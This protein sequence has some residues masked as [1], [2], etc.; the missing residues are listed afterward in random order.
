MAEFRNNAAEFV[1]VRTY[2][3]WQEEKGRRETW[4]ETVDRYLTFVSSHLGDKI[5]EKVYRKIKDYMLE[6]AVMPSMRAV[7]TAGGAAEKDNTCLY[8]CSFLNINRIDAFAECLYILMCGTGVG[9]SVE[10]EHVEKLPEVPPMTPDSLGTYVVEDSRAGW[11]D[12]LK[13]LIS[14]LYSGRDV[15]LDY[16]QLRKKGARLHTMGGRS[17]GPAPLIKLHEYIKDVFDKAQGRKLTNLECHDICCQIA[18]IVVVGGVRRSALISISDLD[19]E[20]LRHAKDW[21]FPVRRFMANNSAIY[22]T[23]PSAAT[24]L[25]E[26][27][28]LAASGTGERGIF[29]R[30]SARSGL[31]AGRRNNTLIAGIN[32]CAEINLRDME[33]CNL[34]ELVVRPDDDLDTLLDKVTTATW[35]GAIQSTFTHF[36]YL[37]PKWKENCVEER[38]LGVSVTGQMDNPEL[39]SEAAWA[40][41]KSRA[42][43][44]A[45]HAARKLEINVPAA[46]T[47]VKPSGN[48]SQ[49]V[50]CSSGIHARYAP[51]YIRRYRIAATD[52][53]FHMLRDQ[54][55]KLKPE[56]G[57]RRKDWRK[58]AKTE[59][60]LA[61][62][63]ICP[64]YR[65]GEEWSESEVNTWVAEFPV[66]SPNTAT[67]RE[68]MTA[69]E[70]LEW[71]KRVQ[72]N[73]CEHNASMTVYVKDDEWIE[74]GNWVYKNWDVINGVSFL[75]YD[76]GKYELAPYEKIDRKTYNKMVE[77]FPEI[78]YS[79]LGKYENEDNT[80]GQQ[81]LACTGDKCELT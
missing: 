23:K 80:I 47:C 63:N 77:S 76:G 40:A 64:I 34:S 50:D 33:F 35:I 32:P 67:M 37:N 7:R 66:R 49:L 68:D 71:Y 24:F 48:L 6:F 21:P 52:P 26:W 17:S 75:P 20:P 81:E 43:K 5:P 42:I 41:M 3:R 59:D 45:R 13:A 12:S 65:D 54:G 79:M 51:Y 57:Q 39:L 22:D 10:K 28:S 55:L 15:D 19:D 18:E 60:P 31:S 53:L 73:W 61:R 9:Y 1:Y 46:I 29:N 14:A 70:Q 62:A 27:G 69:I 56:V 58:A 72:S 44:T 4:P 78:D 38:L 74:V 36:P 11:A 8:N 30:G 25:K 2:A 16:S